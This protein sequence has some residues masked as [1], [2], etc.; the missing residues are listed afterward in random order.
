MHRLATLLVGT[1]ILMA[2]S[3]IVTAAEIIVQ[4]GGSI[5]SAI[6]SA[7]S[8]DVI[9]IKSGTYTENIRITTTPN[10]VIRSESGRPEDTIITAKSSVTSVVLH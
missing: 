5:Q 6:S 7:S 3:G 10:L 4:P 1:L 9:I 2:C 8:G